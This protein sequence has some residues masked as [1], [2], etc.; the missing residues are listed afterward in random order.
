[1]EPPRGND[2]PVW[3]GGGPGVS[4]TDARG[5]CPCGQIWSGATGWGDKVSWVGAGRGRLTL[6]GWGFTHR[7]AAPQED[8]P[9]TLSLR[10]SELA[11]SV[12]GTGE[13]E[14]GTQAF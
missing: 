8:G 10:E 12:P 13:E 7:G 4:M 14:G 9:R 6:A 3:G 11:W 1:M 2:C 5:T